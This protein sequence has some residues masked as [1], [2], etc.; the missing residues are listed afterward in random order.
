MSLCAPS[1]RAGQAQR[2]RILLLAAD[3]VSVKEIV[4]RIGVSKPTVIDGKKRYTAE[5]LGGWP[6]DPS[7]DGRSWSTRWRG[8]GHVGATAGAARRHALALAAAGR[9]TGSVACLGE[10][11]LAPLRAGALAGGELQVLHRPEPQAKVRDVVGL[12]LNPPHSRWPP[13]KV[14]DLCLP[15]HRHQEFL[16]FL[17]QVTKAHPQSSCTGMR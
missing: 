8:A 6:T 3:G 15:R 4:E 11:D 9:R 17:K 7:P 14:T 5:G 12:Y 1:A 10:Q 16:R 13:G 2:A